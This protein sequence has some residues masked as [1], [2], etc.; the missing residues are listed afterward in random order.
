LATSLAVLSTSAGATLS[1]TAAT[2]GAVTVASSALQIVLA[3]KKM[4]S[5]Y[6]IN[7]Q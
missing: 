5:I 2:T 7:L 6:P 1:M 4:K 3:I